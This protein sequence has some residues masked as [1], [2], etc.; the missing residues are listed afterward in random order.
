MAQRLA[1]Y[2]RYYSSHRPADD[3]GARPLVL[4]VFDDPIAPTHFLEVALRE[5]ARVRVELPLLASHRELVEREGPLG[6]AWR[7][8]AATSS[9]CNP[10]VTTSETPRKRRTIA[11]R[12]YYVGESE[13]PTLHVT[14]ALGVDAEHWPYL[15]ERVKNWRWVMEDDY[16]VPSGANLRWADLLAGTG[17]PFTLG[18]LRRWPDPE[19]GAEVIMHGLRTLEHARGTP[20][21]IGVINVC[22]RK[23][24]F[25]RYRAA[26]RGRLLDRISDS[27]AADGRYALL[28]EDEDSRTACPPRHPCPSTRLPRPEAAGAGGMAAPVGT[29]AGARASTL[30]TIAWPGMTSSCNWPA[31]SPTACSS[32]RRRRR[33]RS[34]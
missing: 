26:A 2:L 32:R 21:G 19:R 6:R 28:I 1:P 15:A 22:L 16:R 8:R 30:R 20:D 7:R 10:C 23:R 14:T 9:R 34:L 33:W 4:V 24:R 5:T 27:L 3:H 25:R 29:S 31:W 13:G 11:M 17:N 18:H 12:I